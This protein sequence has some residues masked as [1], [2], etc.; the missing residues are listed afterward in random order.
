M[1]LIESAHIG[2]IS[3]GEATLPTSRACNA[4]LVIG[5]SKFFANFVRARWSY[6][7]RHDRGINR[8]NNM[9]TMHTP[10]N[11]RRHIPERRSVGM[12]RT[13]GGVSGLDWV[14]MILMIIGGL[15]WGLVGAF[16]LNIVSAVFGDRTAPARFVY[17]LVG[18]ASLWGIYLLTRQAANK[19]A[20]G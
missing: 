17:A 5:S 16:D 15:N 12:S 6:L 2:T 4:G 9:A 14:A 10:A 3:V 8:R 18:L 13:R 1:V 7:Y 11:E 19:T 20:Q